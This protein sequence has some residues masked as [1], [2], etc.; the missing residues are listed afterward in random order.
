MPSKL[1]T[2]PK[3]ELHNHRLAHI[4]TQHTH[5]YSAAKLKNK[6]NRVSNMSPTINFKR[7]SKQCTTQ[8][9]HKSNH[10][11]KCAQTTTKHIRT[12]QRTPTHH[13]EQHQK[14]HKSTQCT[15]KRPLN[16]AYQHLSKSHINICETT[17]TFSRNQN[18]AHANAKAY[19][20]AHQ[21]L[22]NSQ[23]NACVNHKSTFAQIKT[24]HIRT[25]Q[26]ASTIAWQTPAPPNFENL[27]TFAQIKKV[28]YVRVE[29][30]DLCVA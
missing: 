25:K 20:N 12:T 28:K 30:F 23:I 27:S 22:R 11:S 10:T 15:P 14:L 19:K 5:Q 17:H 3:L 8:H 9:L 7:K 4:N 26:R 18:N 13:K 29:S 21:H 24:K 1:T 6:T 2:H 16:N